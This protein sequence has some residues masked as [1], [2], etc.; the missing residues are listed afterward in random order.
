MTTS[1]ARNYV[2]FADDDPD[3]RQLVLDSFS[4]YATNVEVI[5][6][7]DGGEAYSL[8]QEL[9]PEINLCLI[10]LDINMP[11]MNG[12]DLLVKLRQ[13]E[14]YADTPVAL[15]TTSTQPMDKVFAEQ[16]KAGFVSKPLN[17]K[18]MQSITEQFIG[19]CE[20]GIRGNLRKEL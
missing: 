18:Q 3:D 6:A 11:V 7:A 17:V 16:Y 4:Q 12:K 5:T 19:F 14:R 13:L 9:D 15:F 1:A 8:M 10:I 2:F 20:D